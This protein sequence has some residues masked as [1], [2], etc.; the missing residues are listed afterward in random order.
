METIDSN[1]LQSMK[2]EEQNSL[3]ADVSSNAMDFKLEQKANACIPILDINDGIVAVSI[4]RSAK[5]ISSPLI[6]EL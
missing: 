2:E 4:L 6:K 1:F 3:S 5:M